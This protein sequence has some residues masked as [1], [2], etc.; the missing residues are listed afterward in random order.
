MHK[1]KQ[2]KDFL[3]RN[4]PIEIYRLLDK[5][6]KDH[7][8]SKTQEALVAL[9]NGLSIYRQVKQPIPF[10][11]GKEISSQFIEDSIREDRG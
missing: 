4:M 9:T 6:A 8:R 11:W 1:K 5:L 3:I 7:Q 2:T 10:D